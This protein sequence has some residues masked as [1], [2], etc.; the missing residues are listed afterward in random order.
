MDIRGWLAVILIFG[1]AA[2]TVGVACKS[3][4]RFWAV[5]GLLGLAVVAVVSLLALILLP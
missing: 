2:T 5:I 4:S 1:L 3:M